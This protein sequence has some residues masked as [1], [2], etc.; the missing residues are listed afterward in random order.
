MIGQQVD[1]L[2]RLQG[3]GKTDN[4]REIVRSVP[5]SEQVQRYAVRLV[6][7]TQP[8]SEYAPAMVNEFVSLGS[9]PRGAQSLLLGGKVITWEPPGG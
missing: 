8:G 4:L 2:N 9:S 7:A 6:M 5:V 3:T 1:S